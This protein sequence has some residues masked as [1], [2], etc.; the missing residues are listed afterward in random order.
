MAVFQYHYNDASGRISSILPFISI[1]SSLLQTRLQVIVCAVWQPGCG[2]WVQ[3]LD[4]AFW[5]LAAQACS[6]KPGLAPSL[7]GV[8]WAR[9]LV[10]MGGS[11]CR[12]MLCFLVLALSRFQQPAS[13]DGAALPSCAAGAPTMARLNHWFG[14]QRERG[15]CLKTWVTISTNMRCRL[16][17]KQGESG[18]RL[19]PETGRAKKSAGIGQEGWDAARALSY[20]WAGS[21]PVQTRARVYQLSRKA[22]NR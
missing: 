20:P 18:E 22:P 13:G 9:G 19:S 4:R 10:C 15:K 8:A 1:R 3:T 7:R 2:T 14:Q 11:A 16:R 17:A 21:K 6:I 12:R 5:P